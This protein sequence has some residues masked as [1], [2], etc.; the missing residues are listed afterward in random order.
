MKELKMYF[1]MLKKR[2]EDAIFKQDKNQQ[3]QAQ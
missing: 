1:L 2:V 3:A